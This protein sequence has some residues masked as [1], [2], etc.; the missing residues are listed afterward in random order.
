MTVITYANQNGYNPDM[1]CLFMQTA[2][3]HNDN[4]LQVLHNGI[5]INPD[6]LHR[7]ILEIVYIMVLIFNELVE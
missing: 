3:Y 5:Y 7:R 1:D 4:Q 6:R 2:D